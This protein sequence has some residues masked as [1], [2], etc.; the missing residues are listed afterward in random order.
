MLQPFPF[1]LRPSSIHCSLVWLAPRQQR[2]V[3]WVISCH[4]RATRRHDRVV[5]CKQMNRPGAVDE[6]QNYFKTCKTIYSQHESMNNNKIKK[7]D[8]RV[9][10]RTHLGR[11]FAV[12][13]R[14]IIS[15]EID[16]GRINCHV[17]LLLLLLLM[18]MMGLFLTIWHYKRHFYQCHGSSQSRLSNASTMMG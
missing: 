10:H 6:V 8:A 2:A 5:H 1:Q 13:G 4:G 18:M 11:F 16:S 7:K 12:R 17:M 3:P 15:G 9:N 14:R